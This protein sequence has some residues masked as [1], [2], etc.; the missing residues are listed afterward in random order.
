MEESRA[1]DLKLHANAQSDWAGTCQRCGM[2]LL[3]ALKDFE[4][5]ARECPDGT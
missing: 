3:G 4:K 2:E 1:Y 5:H